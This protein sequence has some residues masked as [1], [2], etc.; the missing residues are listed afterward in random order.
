M[1]MV[2]PALAYLDVIHRVRDRV[3]VPL[4]AYNV[5]REYSMVK[6]VC[7]AGVAD[8]CAMVHEILSAIKRAGADVIVTY[9]ALDVARWL[10][11]GRW[12]G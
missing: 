10:R 3:D 9:H 7:G 5:S 12:P 2:K 6:G 8:E 1:V 4:I 11:D